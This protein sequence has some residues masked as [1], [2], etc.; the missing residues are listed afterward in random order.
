MKLTRI[1]VSEN[2]LE[3]YQKR[4][5]NYEVNRSGVKEH[6]I[7]YLRSKGFTDI[8]SVYG[9]ICSMGYS[10][11]KV[12]IAIKILINATKIITLVEDTTYVFYVTPVQRSVYKERV[13]KE[14]MEIEK[15]EKN[16]LLRYLIKHYD[17]EELA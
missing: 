3:R 9:H 16:R 17:R 11:E 5:L 15:K 14:V 1:P 7:A 4:N 10:R 12:D 2:A 6:I 8:H 13:K